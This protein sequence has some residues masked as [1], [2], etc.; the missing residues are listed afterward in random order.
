VSRTDEG[1]TRIEELL[2]E[3]LRWQRAASMSTVRETVAGALS[4]TQLR[5]AYELCDGT[6]AS[7]DIAAEVGISPQGFSNWTRRW[8]NLGI[9][10]E[11]EG[12]RIS[13]LISLAALGIPIELK[14]SE[15]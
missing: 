5:K 6:K 12:R 14:E 8:R 1:Q 11:V 4:T 2:T 9:A 13:H 3:Q 7:S 10:Y 15:G